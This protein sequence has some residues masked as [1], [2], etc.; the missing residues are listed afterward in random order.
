MPRSNDPM[1]LIHALEDRYDELRFN[2]SSK[3]NA[4]N[5]V[6]EVDDL[7]EMYIDP[8]FNSVRSKIIK[9][10]IATE[11]EVD[12]V[13]EVTGDKSVD[14]LNDIINARTGYDDINTYIG[15]VYRR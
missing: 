1:D 14:V 2:A 7:D 3:I 8:E 15:E 4:A 6:D 12:L 10:N 11:D 9:Y 5:L 13:C